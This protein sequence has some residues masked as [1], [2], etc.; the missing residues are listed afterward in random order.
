MILLVMALGVALL[1][2]FLVAFG[3]A[4]ALVD[5]IGHKCSARNIKFEVKVLC[6]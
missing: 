5:L 2:E 4:N 6:T 1:G 3:I